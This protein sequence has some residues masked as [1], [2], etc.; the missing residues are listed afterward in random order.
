LQ[1]L[2]AGNV[3]PFIGGNFEGGA[4]GITICRGG[5]LEFAV[6]RSFVHPK[7]YPFQVRNVLGIPY[8]FV[9]DCLSVD[10][11]QLPCPDCAV[12]LAQRF[13]DFPAPFFLF[14]L[15]LSLFIEVG[16]EARE[17]RTSPLRSLFCCAGWPRF[18]AAILGSIVEL[19][20]AVSL[21]KL[22][23][24]LTT[25]EALLGVTPHSTGTL[26]YGFASEEACTYDDT[27]RTG[28]E[29]EHI[30]NIFDNYI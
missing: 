11:Y 29:L 16:D 7:L 17:T 15:K 21:I 27:E 8:N 18:I 9:P 10:F 13:C 28:N 30:L 6:L 14:H 3:L 25:K 1:F 20:E 22:L 4:V 2:F 19:H 5:C 24:G 23:D 12:A 26:L